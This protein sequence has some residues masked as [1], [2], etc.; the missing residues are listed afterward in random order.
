MPILFSFLLRFWYKLQM[1]NYFLDSTSAKRDI[2]YIKCNYRREITLTITMENILI[3][4]NIL[5]ISNISIGK[6]DLLQNSWRNVSLLF[7]CSYFISIYIITVTLSERL[8][9]TLQDGI[10]FSKL[11]IIAYNKIRSHF[12]IR[13]YFSLCH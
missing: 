6:I 9:K 4:S 11:N 10:H 13:S 7:I 1:W 3:Y 8:R 12:P 2:N 5:K